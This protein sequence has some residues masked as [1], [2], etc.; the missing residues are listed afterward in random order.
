[1]HFKV[2]FTRFSHGTQEVAAAALKA[3]E[4]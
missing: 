1:V 2:W 4:I 3:N